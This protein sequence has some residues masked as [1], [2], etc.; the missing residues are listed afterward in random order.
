MRVDDEILFDNEDISQ[1]TSTPTK[2]VAPADAELSYHIDISDEESGAASVQVSSISSDTVPVPEISLLSSCPSE[3][4]PEHSAIC[5]NISEAA[6]KPLHYK[7]EVDNIDK[8]IKPRHMR[9][10]AQ[11]KS[12]HYVQIYCARHRVD[13]SAL[14][15]EQPSEIRIDRNSLCD[16][17]LPSD[18]DHIQ[19]KENFAILIARTMCGNVPFFSDE[20]NK[21]K[22]L[23]ESHIPH[24]YSTE[25]AQLSEVVSVNK[26][27]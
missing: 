6:H 8:T 10:D 3:P 12:L 18:E 14:S 9:E 25:M 13:F 16:K 1:L 23:I 7:L 26:I 22:A 27:T 20:G 21:F 2:L 17:M 11:T 19:M 15:D 24:K 4:P 5:G